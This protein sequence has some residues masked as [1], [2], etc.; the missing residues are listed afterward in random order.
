MRIGRGF[1][2]V[3]AIAAAV[4]SA[5]GQT[6]QTK[7]GAASAPTVLP[8]SGKAALGHV[9][10]LTQM[11]PRPSGSP[12]HLH[13]RNYIR[14][15]LASWNLNPQFQTFDAQTPLGKVQMHNIIVKIPGATDRVVIV[16]GHYDTKRMPEIKFVG[17]NDG[18]SSA[19]L[20]LELAR[21]LGTGPKKDV[22]VWVVFLDGEE[23]YA[24]EWTSSDSLYGSKYL[25]KSLR[26]SGEASKVAA[27]VN[28]D[29]IGDK[30]LDLLFDTNSSGWLNTMVREVA[31][32]MGLQKAFGNL[33]TEMEDDHMPFLASGIP[34][35]DL[36]DFTYGPKDIPADPDKGYWHNAKDSTDKLSAASLETVGKIVLGTVDA[37]AARKP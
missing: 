21:V 18:G 28:I 13:M 29:M 37:I 4:T 25:A 23:A 12:A 34:A 7:K 17:A 2:A 5:A 30:D 35:I 11:G 16:S 10:A 1:L 33:K 20:L 19:G 15:A 6:K 22:A 26:D 14:A 24:G 3:V 9:V 8:L 27:V 36:I 32:K 31:A